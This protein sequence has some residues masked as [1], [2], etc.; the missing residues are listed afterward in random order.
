MALMLSA[1]P[2]QLDDIGHP[3]QHSVPSFRSVLGPVLTTMC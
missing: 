1:F 3:Q 2:D